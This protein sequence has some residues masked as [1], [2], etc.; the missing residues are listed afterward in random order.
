MATRQTWASALF[1]AGI[2]IALTAVIA[3][4][5]KYPGPWGAPWFIACIIVAFGLLVGAVTLLFSA[6]RATPLLTFGDPNPST[7]RF[8]EMPGKPEAQFLR[9]EIENR[10]KTKSGHEDARNVSARLTFQSES[11]NGEILGRW[12]HLPS[13]ANWS[14]THVA[15]LIDIPVGNPFILDIAC[16]MVTEADFYAY[17]DVSVVEGHKKYPLGKTANVTIE[18][19]SPNA[20]W[21]KAEYLLR[22]GKTGEAPHM[23]RVARPKK[24]YRRSPGA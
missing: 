20:R 12:S 1:V 24:W 21:A 19:R 3:A 9:V 18:V 16:Q 15:S 14:A 2:V 10:P 5:T 7:S 23:E 13:P 11:F 22:A 17:N 6:R 8:A 4:A